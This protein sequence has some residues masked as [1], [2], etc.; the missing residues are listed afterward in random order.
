MDERI[1]FTQEDFLENKGINFQRY[2][3]NNDIE[4]DE[5]FE[6]VKNNAYRRIKDEI[7][8]RSTRK[9]NLDNYA[10]FQLEAL[11]YA[12]MDL[13]EF[14]LNAFDTYAFNGYNPDGSRIMLCPYYIIEN[15]RSN[16]LITM[17]VGRKY[18]C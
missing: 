8:K 10:D 16:G 6:I 15:L 9:V 2:I 11:K 4:I 5:Y 7:E 17:R 1:D 14:T 3:T 12:V 13:I 18:V